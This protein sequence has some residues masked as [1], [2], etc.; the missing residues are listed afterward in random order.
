MKTLYQYIKGDNSYFKLTDSQKTQLLEYDKMYGD[1]YKEFWYKWDRTDCKNLDEEFEKFISARKSNKKYYPQLEL[2]KDSLDETWVGKALELKTKFSTFECFLSKYYIQNIDYMFHQVNMTLH[3][4]DPYILM[5]YNQVMT[6]EVSDEAY[7]FA[8]ELIKK[9]PYIDKRQDQPYRGKDVLPM[10]Q[11]HM[12][13]REYGFDIKLNPYMIARQNVEPH[14]KTLHIKTDAYFSDLDVESLRIHEIDVHV[15]RRYYGYKTG[16]NLFADGLLYRNTLDE[17]LAI[18][19]SL[20]HNKFGVKPNLQFDIAIKTIIG[21]H[22]LEKDFC[23]LYDMLI[24]KGTTDQNA[25]IIEKIVF[26]N[27][28]RFKRVLGDCSKYGG[29]SHGET[30]YLLGYLMIKDMSDKERDDVLKYNIGP[31]QI[32]ELPDIK[33]FFKYNK[34]KPLI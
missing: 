17:G 30:D 4:D 10:M 13:K 22:I 9:H 11:S 29:D 25:K 19:Q 3:K 14:N 32:K 21:K 5:K 12:D 27:L 24:D 33:R 26:K 23:E 1:L 20:H 31:D 8:W 15:A 16:L 7:E 6:H 18:N 28:C 34:F 2:V